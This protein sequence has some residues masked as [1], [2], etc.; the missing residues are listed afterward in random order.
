MGIDG[1][2]VE[3]FV[4]AGGPKQ[5]SMSLRLSLLRW[6]E[7]HKSRNRT[8]LGALHELVISLEE[9]DPAGT[10]VRQGYFVVLAISPEGNL[11]RAPL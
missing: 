6:F 11:G 8:G 7:V 2:A 4:Q 1:I 9:R 3:R 5:I 10:L